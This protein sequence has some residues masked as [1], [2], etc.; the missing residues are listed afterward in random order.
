MRAPGRSELVQAAA[1]AC[2]LW[3]STWSPVRAALVFGVSAAEVRI[4]LGLDRSLRGA[5]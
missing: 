3:P 2:R 5:A 1:Q 4:E